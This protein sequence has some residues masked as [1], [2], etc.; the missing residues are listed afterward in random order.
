MTC[1]N[2]KFMFAFV[3]IPYNKKLHVQS[4]C[5]K[6]LKYCHLWTAFNYRKG[7]TQT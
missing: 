1:D 2:E 4:Y 3:C 6:W 7:N 5:A